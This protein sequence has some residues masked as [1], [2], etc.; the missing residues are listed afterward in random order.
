MRDPDL[1]ALGVRPRSGRPHPIHGGAMPREY[2]EVVCYVIEHD[3]L[4][5]FVL[6]RWTATWCRA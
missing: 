6:R 1:D 3:H 2:D 4:L 5:A